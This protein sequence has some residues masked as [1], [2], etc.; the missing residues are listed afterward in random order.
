MLL[1]RDKS[2]NVKFVG[3]TNCY[4]VADEKEKESYGN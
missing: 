1:K 4:I 2:T 3:E